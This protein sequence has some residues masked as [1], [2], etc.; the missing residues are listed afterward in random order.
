LIDYIQLKYRPT[1]NP[2]ALDT[3]D[4]NCNPGKHWH[5]LFK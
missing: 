1:N 3:L 5:Q 4:T 2:A